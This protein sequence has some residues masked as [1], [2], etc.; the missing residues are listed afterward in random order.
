MLN[1]F[2]ANKKAVVVCLVLAAILFIGCAVYAVHSF[3]TYSG[4]K[5]NELS[6]T[7]KDN[8]KWAYEAQ[9]AVNE[10]SGD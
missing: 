6:D 5:W 7:E 4:P 2:K 9:Q 8:A 10:A 3:S 1:D